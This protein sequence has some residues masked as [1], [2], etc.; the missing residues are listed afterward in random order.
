MPILY[1]PLFDDQMAYNGMILTTGYP[2]NSC[3]PKLI[4]FSGKRLKDILK[5]DIFK[6][7]KNGLF[8]KILV[9]ETEFEFENEVGIFEITQGFCGGI[10]KITEIES[11][12]GGI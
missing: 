8:A 12:L 11:Q 9:H 1:T 5:T 4:S 3:F 10:V 7:I 6:N 2:F